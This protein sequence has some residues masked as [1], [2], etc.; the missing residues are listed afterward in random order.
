V[1]SLHD[2]DA[3]PIVKGRL[4]KPVEFGYKAQLVDNEDGVILDHNIEQGNPP[5]APML[6]P[7][8]QR[9]KRRTG[10][11]PRA[12]TAD[13]GYG[14]HWA[15]A[16]RVERPRDPRLGPTAATLPFPVSTGLKQSPR[17]R[18]RAYAPHEKRRDITTSARPLVGGTVAWRRPVT[19]P[20]EQTTTFTAPPPAPSRRGG[21][22]RVR[23]R[24]SVEVRLDV[25][26]SNDECV[27]KLGCRRF[28][29]W[30]AI[31]S[32]DNCARNEHVHLTDGQDQAG[33]AVVGIEFDRGVVGQISR[34]LSTVDIVCDQ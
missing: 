33:V 17:K 14:E 24:N 31:N 30:R 11:A 18:L 1:V 7:A 6:E 8:I 9:I 12:V 29:V 10:R 25:R 34:R 23:Q 19:P 3:R 5:D 22:L 16:G 27:V 26:G 15:A 13:R 2:A 21:R 4:G 32:V 28:V 20:R